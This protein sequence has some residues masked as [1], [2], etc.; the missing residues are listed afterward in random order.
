M[1]RQLFQSF[2]QGEMAVTRKYGGTGLGLAISRRLTEMMGGRIG[3]ESQKGQGAR[4][5]FTVRLQPALSKRP[6]LASQKAAARPVD[7]PNA[8]HPRLRVL[9]VEDNP[10]NQQVAMAVLGKLGIVPDLAENGVQALDRLRQ[11]PYD[12]VIMDVQMPEMDGIEAT[13]RIRRGDGGG[14]NT[15]VP[16]VAMSANALKGDRERYLAAGMNDYVAKPFEPEHLFAVLQ[17][18][19]DFNGRAKGADGAD[20]ARQPAEAEAPP[21]FSPDEARQRLLGDEDLFKDLVRTFLHHIPKEV[22]QLSQALAEPQSDRVVHQA[23]TLKGMCANI[24]A[25]GLQE[26]FAILEEA[27]RQGDLEKAGQLMR[28]IQ[29]QE[30]PAF[31]R[32]AESVLQNE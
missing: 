4:F 14:R 13:R 25:H 23:H 15:A 16:I 22:N 6:P 31:L 32:Q 30:L 28:D 21:A 10:I 29:N 11:R 27:A 5:S 20:S 8:H 19:L 26:R 17:R 24:S 12:M 3:V 1:Q 7:A 2:S 18:Y 9:L